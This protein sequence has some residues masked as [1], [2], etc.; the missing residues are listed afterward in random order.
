MKIAIPV[1]SK[2]HSDKISN[3]FGRSDLFAFYDKEKGN[4][5]FVQNPGKDEASG[6]GIKAAQYL[7]EK[8]ISKVYME[9]VGP[10]AESALSNL[11]I[12]FKIVKKDNTLGEI[13]SSLK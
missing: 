7:K 11:G 13:L 4:L 1:N 2:N 10:R 9:K 5:E 6:A 3:V 12:D 8:N